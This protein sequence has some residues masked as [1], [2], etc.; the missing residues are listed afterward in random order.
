MSTAAPAVFPGISNENEFFSH[1]YLSELFDGDIKETVKRWNETEAAD[2]ERTAPHKRLRALRD[3]HTRLLRRAEKAVD[4]ATRL[5]H[6]REWHRELLGALGYDCRPAN[7][8]LEDGDEIPV[9][10]ALGDQEP[11]A[12]RTAAATSRSAN[13]LV[14]AAFSE[15]PDA[16]EDPLTV[17]P[18][19]LQFHG[20]APPPPHLLEEAW[21]HIITRRV[22]SQNRAPR[23]VLLLSFSQLVLIE[24]GKWAHSRVLRFDFEEILGRAEDATLKATAALLHRSSLLPGEGAQPLL[25][26]LD[27]NSH[28]HAFAVSTD[29][30]YA[31][32]ES[33]ELIGN[34]AIR[35]LREVSHER[36]YNLDDQLAGELGLE[37]VRYMYRL[38]F[39]FYIEARPELG[40]APVNSDAYLSGYS[41]E[42]LRDLELVELATEESRNGFHLHESIQTLF[43]LIRDGFDGQ[44]W[45]GSEDLFAAPALLRHGFQI[46]ALDS[47]LFRKGSTSLLDRVK[48]RNHVLQRVL[49]L[50][51]LSRPVNG[52]GRKRRGRISYAQLGV[53]QL[54]AVYESLLSYRGFFAETE[55]Y[56]VKKAKDKQDDLAGAWFVR[57]D[58]LDRYSEEERVYDI[59]ENGRKLRIPTHA[60]H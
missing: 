46:R 44:Q 10:C 13:L 36:V 20:E 41:L 59:D 60:D 7:H 21:E 8:R 45:G 48:L 54:G 5:A 56:E 49:E 17:R 6:Q 30:K 53:N 51:S 34:E 19:S 14:V 28:R 24:G 40:Y 39:L 32:R 3:T 35:Y 29:L 1:H 22:F 4:G 33:I 9:L 38:L 26:G 58:E 27:E 16:T 25:D 50:M 11:Q 31:M 12:R 55:L 37:C 2:P 23:W 43:R 57:A 18:S 42:R 15:G 52:R 47:A